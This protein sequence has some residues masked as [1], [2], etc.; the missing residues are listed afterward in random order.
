MS[1]LKI[2]LIGRLGKD[3]D[4]RMR[5]DGSVAIG[6]SVATVERYKDKKGESQEKTTW[7]DCVLWRTRDKLKIVDYL[8]K[9]LTVW[10][11]GFPSVNVWSDKNDNSARGTLVVRVDRI[12]MLGGG[13]RPVVAPEAPLETAST[14]SSDSKVFT[15]ASPND[16]LPF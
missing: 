9:G 8:R 16:D 5:D 15:A 1:R 11:E 13:D 14:T 2:E 10:I 12:I 7:V 3:C 4:P 6:F